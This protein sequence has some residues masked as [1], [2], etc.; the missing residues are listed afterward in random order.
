VSRRSPSRRRARGVYS[1]GDVEP[2]R[3]AESSGY[4]PCSGSVDAPFIRRTRRRRK[5]LSFA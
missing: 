5:S 1:H 4:L 3:Y 2:F